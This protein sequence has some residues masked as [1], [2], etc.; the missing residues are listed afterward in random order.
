[1]DMNIWLTAVIAMIAEGI[2]LEIGIILL[3]IFRVR[4]S[5]LIGMLFGGTS[6]LMIA[7]ICFDVL[8]HALEKNRIDLVIIGV[9]IGVT[10]GLL[11][12]D[13][14]PYLEKAVK[15]EGS[16]LLRTAFTLMVGIALHNIPEGF[17]LGTLSHVSF[18]AIRKFAFV[19]MLH[20]IPEGI[21]LA[22]AFKQ[23]RIKLVFL[24][25]IPVLLASIMGLG[26]ILGH[27][28]GNINPGYI[29]TALG[30][31]AG[32]ILYIVCEEL[33]PESRKIWNGR[34]TALATIVGIMIGLIILQ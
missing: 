26:A 7:L 9:M 16:R 2:G 31:A 22:V 18:D 21:A 20:S 25:I 15:I 33:I 1:M 19:L 5:R 4:S 30:L 10:I 24:M 11:L 17:A 27:I 14:A 29:V 32:I 13:L 3:Y 23:A 34:T 8:P 6:G 12:D 28:L